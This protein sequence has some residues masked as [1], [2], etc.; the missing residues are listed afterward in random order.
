[1][2]MDNPPTQT[3]EEPEKMDTDEKE[4]AV[5]ED[6]EAKKKPKKKGKKEEE[7]QFEVLSNLSRVVPG[8]LKYITFPEGSRYAPVKKVPCLIET[9]LMVAYG[10]CFDYERFETGGGG[11]VY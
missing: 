10:R 2:D 4:E 6:A 8:Q 5:V 7:P 3:H 9:S 1:M 11:R